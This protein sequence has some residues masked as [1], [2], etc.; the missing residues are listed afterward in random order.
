MLGHRLDNFLREQV[1]GRGKT[2]ESGWLDLVDH[3]QER[4]D[5]LPTR[6][7]SEEDFVSG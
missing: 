3:I 4:L 6:L 2:D 5:L 1:R 7:T